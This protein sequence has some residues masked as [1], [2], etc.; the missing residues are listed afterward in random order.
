MKRKQRLVDKGSIPKENYPLP[1]I[2][3]KERNNKCMETGGA[4]VTWGA[5][6]KGGARVF[7]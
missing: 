3:K 6:I 1:L 5:M 7:P 4:M 2:P